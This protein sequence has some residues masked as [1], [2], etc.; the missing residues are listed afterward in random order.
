MYK[1]RLK[2]FGVPLLSFV[3]GVC[4]GVLGNILVTKTF[5]AAGR[6]KGLESVRVTSPDGELDAVLV[7][8]TSGGPL[9][10]IFWYLYVV[11]KGTVAPRDVKRC[12]F[13]ADEL[14]KGAIIWSKPHLI[15]IHYDKASIMQ[16][17]N[18]SIP[19]E[20]GLRY[21]E[22]RLVPTADYSLVTPQGGW[23]PD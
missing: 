2:K 10:G 4:V 23:R 1:P 22:L 12:L 8:D 5:M 16:F 11:P 9:G 15:E 3:L 21:V 19:S 13:F 14:T 6:G 7:E 18:I 17:R 20:N